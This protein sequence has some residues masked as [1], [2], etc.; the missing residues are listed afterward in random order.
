MITNS[1][2]KPVKIISRKIR[3]SARGEMCTLRTRH[4]NGN[5][6]TV[7]FAHVPTTYAGMGT[8]SNDLHGVYACS[9]CHT[10]LDEYLVGHN[11]ILRAL[12]ETQVK[13]YQKDL[14]TVKG[15]K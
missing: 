14:I 3:N 12:V 10:A 5:P 4:C 11:D 13:M 7:V 1:I 15:A 9:G 8:K 6:E 2:P